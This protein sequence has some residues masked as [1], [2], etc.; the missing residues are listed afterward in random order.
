M[1]PAISNYEG[2]LDFTLKFNESGTAKS[3]TSTFSEKLT[4]L[5]C[6]LAKTTPTGILVKKEP[7]PGAVIRATAVY[8]KTEQVAEVV[9]RCPHHQS[10]DTSDNR[11][12]LIRVEGSQ[13]AQ[14][15]EDP[16]TKRQ[17]VTVPY[18]RPQRESEMTTILL[19]FMC[20]SS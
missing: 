1:V 16:K 6:H 9:E 4:K 5:F 20:N 12:H 7:P 17:R 11:S 8:K 13:L 19:S 15:F 2:E 14:Y 3:V 10:E 18:E